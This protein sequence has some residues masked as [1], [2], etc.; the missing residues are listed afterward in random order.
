MQPST[1]ALLLAVAAGEA[2][3]AAVLAHIDA[4][5]PLP[6]AAFR[7][8]QL[9]NAAD[10][11]QGSAKL[12]RFA[13]AEGLSA[14]QALSLFAEHYRSVLADPNGTGHANI[15]QFMQHGWAGL[16]FEAAAAPPSQTAA[17]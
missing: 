5:L 10:A 16:H 15:R 11:N 1:Q 3:F 9:H 13:Q 6:A 4:V 8:G 14:T 2:D 17:T 12:L 7:N